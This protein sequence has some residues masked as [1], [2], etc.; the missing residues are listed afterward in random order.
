[1]TRWTVR[2]SRVVVA[3]VD[4]S[5]S[6]GHRH[7]SSYVTLRYVTKPDDCDY[8]RRM[9][10][11]RAFDAEG[12]STSSALPVNMSAVTRRPP[13]ILHYSLRDDQVSEKNEATYQSL[14]QSFTPDLKVETH[15]VSQILSSV[16]FWCLHG[17]W[18]HTAPA[19][20]LF[21]C[22]FIFLLIFIC[23]LPVLD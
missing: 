18:T 2:C 21:F 10:L 6:R 8:H 22:C 12:Q 16:V 17:I 5:V 1:M 7:A 23:W 13:G 15:F 9:R 3:C 20:C 4:I 19:V 14:F 11:N